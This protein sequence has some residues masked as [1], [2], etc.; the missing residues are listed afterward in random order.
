MLIIGDVHGEL[1]LLKGLLESVKDED[2]YL[3]G[4]IVDRGT[5]SLETLLLVKEKGYKMVLGN[6]EHMMLKCLKSRNIWDE[7]SWFNNGGDKTLAEYNKL[8]EEKQKEILNYLKNLPHYFYI[9]EQDLLISHAGVRGYYLKDENGNVDFGKFLKM[10]KLE[11]F[12]WIRKDF[13]FNGNIEDYS[14]IFIA[15]H[16]P[17][18]TVNFFLEDPTVLRLN[19]RILIDTGAFYTGILGAIQ[20][21]DNKVIAHYFSTDKGYYSEELGALR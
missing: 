12:I 11:D 4:D 8:P 13:I 7:E 3:V 1:E 20:I 10:Q 2:V 18:G 21:I 16:T 17:T 6:H 19:N 14:T 15:G 5:S 9:K